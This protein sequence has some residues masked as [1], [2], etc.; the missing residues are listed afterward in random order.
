MC[1][2]KGYTILSLDDKNIFDKSQHQFLI[3]ASGQRVMPIKA[4]K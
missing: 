4:E 3:K 1:K 2:E